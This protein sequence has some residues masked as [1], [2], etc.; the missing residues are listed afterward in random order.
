MNLKLEGPEK[1]ITDADEDD[2]FINSAEAWQV[3]VGEWINMTSDENIDSEMEQMR[4]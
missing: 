4:H 3:L 2:G 1:E